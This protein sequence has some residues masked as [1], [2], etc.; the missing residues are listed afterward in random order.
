MRNPFSKAISKAVDMKRLKGHEEGSLER[1]DD[2][3]KIIAF[4]CTP[5][6]NSYREWVEKRLAKAMKEAF[7]SLGSDNRE[8]VLLKV[9][10]A[11]AYYQL[12][13]DVE[14]QKAFIGS[15]EQKQTK[16]RSDDTM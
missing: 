12:L 14:S 2:A 8:A 9:A 11:S 7:M 1:L 6:W 13:T 3:N 10:E 16:P 5:E 4:A 15:L